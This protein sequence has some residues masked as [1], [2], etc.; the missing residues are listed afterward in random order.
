MLGGR[1]YASPDEPHSTQ[2]LTVNVF[3][4]VGPHQEERPAEQPIEPPEEA[5]P[6]FSPASIETTITHPAALAE[7]AL[8]VENEHNRAIIAGE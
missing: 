1:N 6:S 3:Q 4:G 8:V 2:L 5:V 7:L